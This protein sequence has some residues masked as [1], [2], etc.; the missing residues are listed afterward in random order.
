LRRCEVKYGVITTMTI[1]WS[2]IILV[3]RKVRYRMI[4]RD[5][6]VQQGMYPS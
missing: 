2:W 5:F 4:K 3:I 1:V 6:V